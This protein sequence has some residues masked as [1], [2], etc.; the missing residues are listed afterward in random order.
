MHK[1]HKHKHQREENQHAKKRMQNTPHLRCAKGLREPL[2]RREEERNPGERD[3]KEADHYRP[4][5]GAIDKLR[6]QDHFALTHDRSPLHRR[7]SLCLAPHR[8]SGKSARRTWRQI[9]Q[10]RAA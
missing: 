6:A 10:R 2:E 8:Y 4:V 1:T 5:T 9:P 7:P 3:Q